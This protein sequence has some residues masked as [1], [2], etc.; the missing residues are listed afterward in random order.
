MCRRLL[1]WDERFFLAVPWRSL[2]NVALRSLVS[3]RDGWDDIG[4]KV[5]PEH[6]DGSERK[7]NAEENE[8]EERKGLVGDVGDGVRN[9]F[10]QILEY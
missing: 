4:S 8:D 6:A 5:D 2:H 10:L 9:G 3:H 7:R 1:R